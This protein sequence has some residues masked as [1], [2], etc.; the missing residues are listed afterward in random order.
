VEQVYASQGEVL[1]I[2]TD[3]NE[4]WTDL[5]VVNDVLKAQAQAGIKVASGNLIAWREGTVGWSADRA[6]FVLA[7]GSEVPCRLTCVF[8]QEGGAWKMVQ[9]HASIGVPNVEALGV[10]V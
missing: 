7:D 9:M 8:H 5:S 4:W 10:D 1:G 2:G 6:R 3:P